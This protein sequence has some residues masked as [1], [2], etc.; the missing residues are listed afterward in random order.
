MTQAF[1]SDIT[2]TLTQIDAEG[3]TK[4][5]RLISSPQGGEIS[6]GGRDMIN[7]CANNYLGLAN[8]P[9]LI[10]AAKNAMD[11][12]GFGMAS[13]R[14]IC[15][16]QDIHRDLEKRLA[17]FLGKDDSILFAACFDAN[18]GLFEPLLGPQDAII[19][20]A[21]NHASIID[22]VRLCKAKRYRFAN[23]DMDDLETQ[24][25]AA[26]TEGARHIMIATDGVF[27]MDG[28][29][30]NLPDITALA[31]EYNALVMVD[32]CHATGFMG[33]KGAGTPAHFGVDVDILTGTLGKALGGAIGGY[34]AG[35]QLV[36]D[37]L[38]Q[39]AR[40]YLFSNSL[41]PAIVSAGIEAIRLVEE[42]DALRAQLFENA[43]YWRAGL[44]TLGF[45][46]LQGEHPIIPVMLGDAQLAQ[47]M[48][49]RLFD[50]GVYVSGFFFPV[51][52]RGQ[53]RIR[54]QMNAALSRSELDRALAAFEIAGKAVGVLS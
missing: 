50:E 26:Q 42:G 34:I 48:A 2:E 18:G 21:L 46:L 20:D 29:L 3:L 14:F 36:I 24:L 12:H 28:Y 44:A 35:P 40:P 27:S 13:V 38:R 43:S 7:L 8:H 15:G 30:A 10:A 22:G 47:D 25:R 11:D 17:G 16:T 6:V 4:R 32:D 54:T 39:R 5:E 1:L 45:E 41:P 53:A 49:T 9:D 37:L 51:V 31:Q 52:P 33:P 19:S 23:S